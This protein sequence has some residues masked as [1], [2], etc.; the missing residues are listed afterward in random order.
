M[1]E[2]PLRAAAAHTAVL[3][4]H[5]L[6]GVMG[7][8]DEETKHY[9]EG[10]PVEVVLSYRDGATKDTQ[11]LWTHHQKT[12]IVDAC[13]P[14]SYLAHHDAVHVE[15]GAS[16]TH[17][18]IVAP[19][20][21][22]GDLDHDGDVDADDLRLKKFDLDHDG[23][24]DSEDMRL[25]RQKIREEQARRRRRRKVC[26]P[27]LYAVTRLMVLCRPGEEETLLLPVRQ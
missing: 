8:C 14:E 18:P 20:Q 23:D 26:L 16:H 3:G 10:T 13:I 6:S 25:R 19:S 7:T 21:A 24:V 9:F 17:Q 11:F 1:H 5:E 2:T 15:S 12:V 27:V 4:L 22:V